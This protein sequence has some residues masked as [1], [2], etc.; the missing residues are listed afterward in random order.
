M[1]KRLIYSVTAQEAGQTVEEILHRNLGLTKRQISQA[2]FRTDGICVNGIRSRISRL[3]RE[4]DEVLVLLEEKSISS[5]HLL[6]FEGKLDILYEDEDLLAVNKPAGLVVH[7]SPGHYEDSLANMLIHYF[8]SR[9]EMVKIRPLGRL[10][11][12]TSGV[13]IFAKNQVAAERLQEQ[14]KTGVFGKEYLALVQGHLKERK[15]EIRIPI[16]KMPG[17]L[18][19]MEAA[20]EGKDAWT[21]YEVAEE[22]RILKEARAIAECNDL[23]EYKIPEFFSLVRLKLQTGRTH[24]IRVHMAWLGHPLLGDQIYGTARD[25]RDGAAGRAALHAARVWLEQPF[26]KENL[27]IE[28]GFPADMQRILRYAR[29]L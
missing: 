24:Q 21:E 6:P 27:V 13:M 7:P 29:A 28:A 25:S 22:Y 11:K 26:T 23:K 3:V 15:G 12:E 10:D 14:R 5:G 17:E 19:K 18:M 8:K 4:K 9:G 16:R 2:K 1:E 20:E